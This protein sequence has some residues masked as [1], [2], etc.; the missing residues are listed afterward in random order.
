VTDR[1]R[2]LTVTVF[3]DED[4]RDDDVQNIVSA[5][6]MIRGVE[7][8]TTHVVTGSDMMNRE[9]VRAEIRREVAE[10]LANVLVPE[11]ARAKKA[12]D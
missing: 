5:I 2:T 11:W 1:I 7:A 3:L 10:A 6:G 9:T 12:G 8:A 4:Y